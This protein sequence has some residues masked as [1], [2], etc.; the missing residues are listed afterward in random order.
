MKILVIRG[1][2]I[3]NMVLF[4]PTLSALRK[5]LPDAKITLITDKACAE[6]IRGS[7]LVDDVMIF[8]FNAPLSEKMKIISALRKI[9][10]DYSLMTFP[11][12][13]WQYNLIAFLMGARVKVSHK[14]SAGGMISLSF[15]QDIRIPAVEGIHDVDQNLNL[16]KVFG[17]KE[18]SKELIFYLS[19]EDRDFA[20]EFF[21]KNKLRKV[22]AMHPGCADDG[23]ATR[24]RWPAEYFTETI[25]SLQDKG[26]Q[27]MLIAGPGEEDLVH[28][29]NG[30]LKIKALVL[31][32]TPL[33]KVV[34]V[35]SMCSGFLSTD[36]G[37]GHTAAAVGI[38]TL[39]LIGP[40]D[41]RRIAPY[42]KKCDVIT[43]TV[44][45]SPC[46]HYPF[47]ATRS[48]FGTSNCDV[49][50]LKIIRPDRVVEKLVSML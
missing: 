8:D 41:S 38:P 37:I 43:K 3:G 34:A 30:P 33:K 11:A 49:R 14:Y 1:K 17:I 29:I 24:R 47:R 25:R 28:R 45:C 42:G 50:C 31:Q 12:N 44:P 26:Y 9:R 4:T 39:A 7:G 10:F 21:K 2:G 36:S 20:K 6:V 16:L 13:K 22:I 32:K 19:S 5:N 27:I 46:V 40:G 35:V 18:V 23:L 15:L 48:K